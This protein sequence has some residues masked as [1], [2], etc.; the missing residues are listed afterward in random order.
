MSITK[1]TSFRLSPEA[2][3]LLDLLASRDGITKTAVLELLIREKA[4]KALPKG[5][6]K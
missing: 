2:R 5:G 6:G 1:N 3:R 4:R